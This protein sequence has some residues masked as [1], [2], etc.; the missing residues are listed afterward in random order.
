MSSN[1]LEEMNR[2]AN[3]PTLCRRCGYKSECMETTQ[4]GFCFGC[5][6]KLKLAPR[7]TEYEERI[8]WLTKE[9]EELKAKLAYSE[10]TT[11]DAR[12]AVE[13]VKNHL[14]ALRTRKKIKN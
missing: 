11:K 6:V 14:S 10:Q 5:R 3:D 1:D 13:V 8:S 2:R 9:V 7:V 4:D 12:A